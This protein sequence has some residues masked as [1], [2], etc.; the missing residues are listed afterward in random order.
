MFDDD[1]E[2]KRALTEV[3]QKKFA[4][5]VYNTPKYNYI[6]PLITV[7]LGTGMRIGEALGLR[8]TDCDFET[9]TI[10]IT[11]AL[12]YKESEDGSGYRYRITLPKTRAGLR[13]IPMFSSVR[14]ALETEKNR[15]RD[16]TKK[17]FTVDGYTDFIF[18]NSNGKPYINTAVFDSLH[19]I[20]D[21]YNLAESIVAYE[22]KRQP[23]LLPHFGAHILRHT[24]C[25]RL[26]ENESNI[27]IVQDVMGHKDVRTTMNVY[28]EATE[29]KKQERFK[30]IDSKVNLI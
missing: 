24:F 3:E 18:L 5:F 22:E 12:V 11:H 21:D 15:Q 23:V 2:R 4:S 20:V 6:A 13:T 28:N 30:E 10:S 17:K 26:C 25:T 29:L 9:N 8:W 19:R 7:L 27:K 14:Q 16:P 1:S